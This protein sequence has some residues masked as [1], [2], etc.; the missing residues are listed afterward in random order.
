MKAAL[1]AGFNFLGVETG[2][3]TAEQFKD[4]RAISIPNVGH[5]LTY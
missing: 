4:A 3:V 5:L 1:G 2:L